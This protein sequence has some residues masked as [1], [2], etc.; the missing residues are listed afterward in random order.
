MNV[1]FFHKHRY[2]LILALFALVVACASVAYLKPAP[3]GDTPSYVEAM[4]VLLGGETPQDFTPNRILT[5]PLSLVL[6]LAF[7]PL[8]GLLHGWLVLNTLFLIVFALAS[9]YLLKEL[10]KDERTALLGALFLIGNYA[11]VAFGPAYLMDMGSWAALMLALLFSIRFI[12]TRTDSDILYAAAA[13]GV[14]TLL[15]EYAILGGIGIAVALTYECIRRYPRFM[16][17]IG[18]AVTSAAIALIPVAVIHFEVY[19]HFQYTYLDWMHYNRDAYHYSSR[20]V[21]YVKALGSLMNVLALASLAGLAVFFG[22]I[23]RGE[24]PAGSIAATAAVLLT[25]I[26]AFVWGGITQRVLFVLVPAAVVFACFFF[27]R[28]RARWVWFLPFV[29]LYVAISFLMDPVILP[30]VN[31]P[32]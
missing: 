12:R 26:P 30:A 10:F 9:L 11:V 15:K 23:R 1:P 27:D 29:A 22:R 21:E 4:S 17:A 32:L 31:L 3:V 20:I 24:I 8:F 2:A 25:G 19:R 13:V 6:V 18:L 16:H 14:G 28:Y 7:A 5:T